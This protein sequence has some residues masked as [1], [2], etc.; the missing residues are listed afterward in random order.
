MTAITILQFSP[1]PEYIFAVARWNHPY[2][3]LKRVK[4][5]RMEWAWSLLILLVDES[6]CFVMIMPHLYWTGK[7]IRIL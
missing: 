5:I 6:R 2:A 3:K 4:G 1:V 7:L